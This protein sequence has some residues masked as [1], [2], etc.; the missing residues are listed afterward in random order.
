MY[1]VTLIS[2]IYDYDYICDYVYINTHI[3]IYIDTYICDID[4]FN[5]YSHVFLQSLHCRFFLG[6]RRTIFI[7]LKPTRIELFMLNYL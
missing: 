1:I 7:L 2:Y 3:Y 4:I 5:I 6:G